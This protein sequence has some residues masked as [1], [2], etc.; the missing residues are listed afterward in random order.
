MFGALAVIAL[1]ASTSAA[2]AMGGA[3]PTG[4]H[5]SGPAAPT[6]GAVVPGV[7]E[8]KG[9][10][11]TSDDM[12]MAPSGAGYIYD[13]VMLM[14]PRIRLRIEIALAGLV[15]AAALLYVAVRPRASLAVASPAFADQRT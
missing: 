12:H 7:P 5:A 1:S 8:W 10:T 9:E 4:F 2:V 14:P 3:C 15:V 6:N 13:S 11:C